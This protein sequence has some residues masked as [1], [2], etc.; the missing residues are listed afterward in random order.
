MD[1]AVVCDRVNLA[2][3]PLQTFRDLRRRSSTDR[4]RRAIFTTRRCHSEAGA[5]TQCALAMR[6]LSLPSRNENALLRITPCV[7][8]R[9]HFY[10]AK[11]I[12][13]FSARRTTSLLQIPAMAPG[14]FKK[15]KMGK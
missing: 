2:L 13:K 8:R 12:P 4:Y 11:F 7:V 14:L 6:S 15:Q 10:R 3:N 1:G 5:S 9:S